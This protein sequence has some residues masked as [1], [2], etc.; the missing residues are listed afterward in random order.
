MDVTAAAGLVGKRLGCER[1][2]QRM[3]QGDRADGFA[4][5]DLVVG[6]LEQ[7]RV[8]DRQLLLRRSELGVVLPRLQVLLVQSV[9]HRAHDR[10]GAVHAIG[11]EAQA[12]VS[13]HEATVVR[14]ACQVELVL[15]CRLDAKS[16][17][18]HAV[19]RLAQKRAWAQLPRLP[20][21]RVHVAQ[22]ARLAGGVRQDGKR[23]PIGNQANLADGAHTGAAREVV[24][25][26]EGL[27][28]HAQPDA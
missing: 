28:G 13:G 10:S 14:L 6:G 20:V 24:C 5:C 22:Q 1:G 16:L 2:Q 17:L 11:A 25:Q 27:H 26:R 12:V 7:R 15:E 21:E 3:L 23:A 19:D 4:H 18:G 8:L 9:Q